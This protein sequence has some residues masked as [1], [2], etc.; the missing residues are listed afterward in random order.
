[1]KKVG[2][3]WRA[4]GPDER[5]RWRADGEEGS[6]VPGATSFVVPK[7]AGRMSSYQ[8]FVRTM[9]QQLKAQDPPSSQADNMRKIGQMWRELGQEERDKYT[10][11]ADDAGLEDD[12]LLQEGRARKKNKHVALDGTTRNLS[13]YNIFVRGMLAQLRAENTEAEQGEHMKRVGSL[14]RAMS[15]EDKAKWRAE[16]SEGSRVGGS[17]TF[18]ASRTVSRPT[19]YQMFVKQM[20]QQLKAEHPDWKQADNMRKIGELWRGMSAEERDRYEPTQAQ[21]AEMQGR[22]KLPVSASVFQSAAG[23]VHSVMLPPGTTRR[24]L[25]AYNLFVRAMQAKMKED[26]ADV[27]QGEHMKK[28][29]EMWRDMSEDDKAKWKPDGE[30][31][32]R[33]PGNTTVISQKSVTQPSAYQM[34]VKQMSKEF[35]LR[36]PES[37]QADNMRKIGELWRDMSEADKNQWRCEDESTLR[38]SSVPLSSLAGLGGAVPGAPA[39][40]QDAAGGARKRANKAAAGGLDLN[41]GGLQVPPASNASPPVGLAAFPDPAADPAAHRGSCSGVTYLARS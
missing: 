34:F 39:A 7:S 17:T 15:D 1:M 5:G 23:G 21:V 2:E 11:S 3:L 32:S 18:V 28:I 31:G 30:E 37:K 10:P 33:V 6:K 41:L 9:T 25:S 24:S 26:G 14:W 13:A 22:Q 36:N 16:G 12:V 8:Q 38:P 40:P 29:G 19:P 35:K 4:L 20:T 27:R